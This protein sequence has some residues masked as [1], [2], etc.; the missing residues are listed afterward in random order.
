MDITEICQECRNY[1]PPANKREDMSYIHTGEYKIQNHTVTPLNFIAVG[2]Y[3][4]I[5]G[6]MMNDGVYCNTV[7]GLADLVDE[8][9]FTGTIWEM[10]VPRAFLALCADITAWRTQNEAIGSAN[11]S[12][13][14]SESFAGYSYQKGGGI[15]QGTGNAMTWQAQFNT[16]LNAWRKAYII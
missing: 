6:S 11:M 1:F 8:D 15:S 13:Y 5:I 12:P 9:T 10:S 2:Q 7:D 14:T 4:R 16:R 3:F